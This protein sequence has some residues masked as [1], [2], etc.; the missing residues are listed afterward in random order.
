MSNENLMPILSEEIMPSDLLNA[1]LPEEPSEKV[2]A[3]A[4]RSVNINMA[5]A[6]AEALKKQIDVKISLLKAKLE[7]YTKE[8]IRMLQE[9]ESGEGT[10][11]FLEIKKNPAKLIIE[12]EEQLK[13]WLKE[14]GMEQYIKV[15]TTESIDKAGL[16]KFGDV[17]LPFTHFEQ[18]LKV[19][20]KFKK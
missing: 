13:E 10:Y 20:A 18:D 8:S 9:G 11:A 1:P 5:L 16:K 19:E 14:N 4:M 12:D 3:L 7:E 15:K 17:G 2:D 6:R